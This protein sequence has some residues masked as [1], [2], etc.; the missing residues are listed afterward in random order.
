VKPILSLEKLSFHYSP[1]KP[2]LKEINFELKE[3]EKVALLGNNGSGKTTIF[4]L[5]VG[6]L[7]PI[8]GNLHLFDKT[9]QTEQDFQPLRLQIGFLFQDSDDQLF[10]PTVLDDV[11]FGV[12]NQGKSPKE[13]ESIARETLSN[14]GLERFVDSTPLKLSGGEKKLVAL[15]TILAMQPR[16]L[17]LDEPTNDLDEIARQRLLEILKQL[18]Q[19]MLVISHDQAFLNQLTTRSILLKDGKLFEI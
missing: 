9:P 11:M 4:H 12:L 2:L 17:L 5:I 14:L 10:C 18:P 3:G 15:A 8:S 13:A 16:L 7:K 1:N 19:A 6:L